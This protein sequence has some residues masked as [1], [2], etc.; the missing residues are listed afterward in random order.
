MAIGD[1]TSV[2]GDVEWWRYAYEN[3][4]EIKKKAKNR[5]TKIER[6]E[7][8]EVA[9]GCRGLPTDSNAIDVVSNGEERM[10]TEMAMKMIEWKKENKRKMW[11][12]SIVIDEGSVARANGWC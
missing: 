5:E 9:H 8:R 3:G 11:E 2:G 12:K 6:G 7:S 10:A 4:Y 1:N